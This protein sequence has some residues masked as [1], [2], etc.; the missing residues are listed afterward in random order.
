MSTFG[1]IKSF[2]LTQKAHDV[3]RTSPEGLLKV[4][5]SGTSRGVLGDQQKKKNDNLMKKVFFR[6]NSSYFTHLLLFFTGKTNMQ[7]F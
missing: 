5:T 1:A 6:Y 2:N 3:P 4:L 7:K